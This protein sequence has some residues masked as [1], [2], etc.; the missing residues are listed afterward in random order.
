MAK[1]KQTTLKIVAATSMTIFSLFALFIGTFAWFSINNNTNVDGDGG[2]KVENHLKSFQRME[3]YSGEYVTKSG[4]DYYRFEPT[5]DA[6]VTISYDG[7]AVGSFVMAEYTAFDRHH[8][9]M[10]VL[11]FDNSLS[12]IDVTATTPTSYFVGD[13]AH[14]GLSQFVGETSKRPLSSFVHTYAFGYENNLPAPTNVSGTN[15]YYYEESV[16]E[17]CATNGGSFV[18]LSGSSFTYNTTCSFAHLSGVSY[19]KIVIILD[20]YQDAIE[21]IVS[22]Y[23]KDLTST[24]DLMCDWTLSV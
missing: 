4:T 10:F 3:I 19:K 17:G 7:S 13:V 9:I 12:S 22:A 18:T 21:Y 8:P 11:S 15:Y 2:M 5:P 1:K 20:Y 16:V 6:T 23:L 14:N 24:I